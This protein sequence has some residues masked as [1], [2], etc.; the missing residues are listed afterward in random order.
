MKDLDEPESQYVRKRRD[1]QRIG[2]YEPLQG[3]EARLE[4]VS[5]TAMQKSKP[6][7][8]VKFCTPRVNFK[9]TYPLV[10]QRTLE[11]AMHADP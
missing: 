10:H 6:A 2:R 11:F 7:E 5:H 8:S 9:L 4:K 1:W 3:E